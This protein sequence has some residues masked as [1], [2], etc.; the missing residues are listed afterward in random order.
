MGI[1]P[2]FYKEIA[3]YGI[4][5]HVEIRTGNQN[6]L[7]CLWPTQEAEAEAMGIPRSFQAVACTESTE[8]RGFLEG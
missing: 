8:V 7:S 2:A 3:E 5:I 4:G 1:V 6:E